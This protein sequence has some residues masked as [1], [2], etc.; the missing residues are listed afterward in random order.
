[1]EKLK[2]IIA[3]IS[4]DQFSVILLILTL[5]IIIFIQ[6]YQYRNLEKELNKIT[7]TLDSIMQKLE[8]Q[9]A[10]AKQSSDNFN[11]IQEQINNL[12]EIV[13]M[14]NR[15][16]ATMTESISGEV[17]IGKAIEMARQGSNSTEISNE[18]NLSLEQAELIFK[19]H[20]VKKQD[21]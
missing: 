9:S 15:D 16:I 1:M 20:G 2:Q 7:F 5:I 12:D 18:T 19:F 14:V 17:G 21:S 13:T 10:V 3:V 8:I 4:I 6:F 11:N